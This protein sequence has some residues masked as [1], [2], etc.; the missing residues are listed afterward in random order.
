LVNRV[1]VAPEQHCNVGHVVVVG[2]QVLLGLKVEKV[3]AARKAKLHLV[4]LERS[5]ENKS[6]ERE[7][8]D[9]KRGY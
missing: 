9:V 6:N 2:L 7:M 1:P 3:V 8:Q 5:R 4:Q